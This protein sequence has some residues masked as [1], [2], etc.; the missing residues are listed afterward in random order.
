M[1]F[2]QTE[3]QERV[4]LKQII[5][6][7]KKTIS[8]T[9]VSVKDHI[10]T[11][12]EYK[13]YLWSNKDIDPHE[14]RSMRESILN[15]FAIGESVIDKRKRFTKMLAIPYFGRIDFQEKKED[16]K[17]IPVYIGIHTF[18]DS[19]TK[20]T[21]IYDWRAPIS[22][23]FYDY[24]LGEASYHSPFKEIEGEISLK[25]QYRIR[26]GEMEFMIES[27]LAVHDDIL[28]KELSSNADN[29]MKNIVATIQREQNRIIRNEEARILIIQGVAGSG[30][31]S[32]ALHRI[33]YLLYAFNDNISSKDILIISPNKVFADY[34]SNVLPE[35][36]NRTGNQYGR[37]TFQ[38]TRL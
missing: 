38:S 11:L 24:E 31:T 28:Q 17:V 15:H 9:D 10:D 36:R 26:G 22:S 18:Y 5:A 29:K 3:K 4:Y 2:S 37:D 21:L 27:S 33:A 19:E 12:A 13:D 34:I 16:A 6:L 20:V 1:V 23:M 25:R 30:K 14:I 8:S 32:I 35:L 7:L